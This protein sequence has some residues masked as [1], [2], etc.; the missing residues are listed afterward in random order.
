MFC[1]ENSAI[2]LPKV[3][4]SSFLDLSPFFIFSIYAV[5][6][7]YF[8]QDGV[9]ISGSNFFYFQIENFQEIS[10]QFAFFCCLNHF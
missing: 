5:K 9:N 4:K 1:F 3:D 8:V 7:G 6:M 10:I 2:G